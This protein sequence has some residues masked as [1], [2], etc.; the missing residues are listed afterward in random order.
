M[1]ATAAPSPSGCQHCGIDQREHMQRWKPPVGWHKW[2]APT[3]DQ[4]KTRMRAR[5]ANA[6]KEN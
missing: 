5:R 3:Q 6:P 4:I 1:V 2:T